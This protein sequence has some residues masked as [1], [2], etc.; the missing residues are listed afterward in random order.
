MRSELR[1]FSSD[2][3]LD[4]DI[5]AALKQMDSMWTAC[6]RKFKNTMEEEGAVI[7]VQKELLMSAVG[8]SDVNV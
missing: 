5:Q 4:P 7:L 6:W 2:V 3:N 1:K 8:P